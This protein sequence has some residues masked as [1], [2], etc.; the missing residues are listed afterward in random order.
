MTYERRYTHPDV[1]TQLGAIFKDIHLQR[2]VGRRPPVYVIGPD[3]EMSFL[4][5]RIVTESDL[6]KIDKD[7]HGELGPAPRRLGKSNRMNPAGITAFYGA[8]D[9]DTCISELRPTVGAQI[10]YAAFKPGRELVLLDMRRFSAPPKELNM[11]A[12]DHVRRLSQWRFMQKFMSEIAKPISPHDEPFDYVATQVVAEY[13]NK[14]HVVYVDK[15]RRHIDGIIYRSAQNPEGANIAL[16]GAAARVDSPPPTP[17]KRWQPPSLVDFM[18][19]EP[20]K[21]AGLV[22]V[23]DSLMLTSAAA[24]K[25]PPGASTPRQWW[26]KPPRRHDTS[27]AVPEEF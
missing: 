1:N 22:L 16:L 25:Y 6:E 10:V 13:L 19:P 12:R 2:D 18:K 21:P 15:D 17:K 11:F 14:V 9:L 23:D 7:T 8:L 27:L 4:R 26:P 5:A 24:A 20:P 3:T